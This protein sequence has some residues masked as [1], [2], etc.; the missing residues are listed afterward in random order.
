VAK[1]RGR[2]VSRYSAFL[3][4]DEREPPMS[5]S[6]PMVPQGKGN[7]G[8]DIDEMLEVITSG[9]TTFAQR[10]LLSPRLTSRSLVAQTL[11]VCCWVHRPYLGWNE[12]WLKASRVDDITPRFQIRKC[13][14]P[15]D[16]SLAV[17]AITSGRPDPAFTRLRTSDASC[18]M[19]TLIPIP[20]HVS[21]ASKRLV[22]VKSPQQS[23]S[24]HQAREEFDT[25]LPFLVY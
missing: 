11:L 8:N 2:K 12:P 7:V 10:L 14:S 6:R 16:R 1:F 24:A 25:N 21:K 18:P 23:A 4:N 5:S 22:H 3:R 19:R 13:P 17:R 15:Q 20:N 9:A